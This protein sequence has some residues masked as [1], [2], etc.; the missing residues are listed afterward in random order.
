M[1]TT[2][3]TSE[4]HD[5]NSSNT[6]PE[7]HAQPRTLRRP[8]DGRMLAGVTAGAAD[9]LGVDVTTARVGMAALAVVGHVAI[10]LY[11]AGW[12]LMPEEGSN[13]SRASEFIQS[14]SARAH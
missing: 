5:Q 14:L 13:Q 8:L 10:P 3:S 2:T 4:N 12:A 7:G 6:G 11:L 9:Y 1:K